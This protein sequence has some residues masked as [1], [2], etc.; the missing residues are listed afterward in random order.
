[1]LG[2]I[3]G[4]DRYFSHR[5][6][7]TSRWLQFLLGCLGCTALQKGPLWWASLHRQ[8]HRYSDK[9]EDVHSPVTGGLSWSPIGWVFARDWNDGK[10]KPVHDLSRFRELRWLDNFDWLPAL[11]LHRFFSSPSQHICPPVR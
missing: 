9:A 2:L 7:K 10:L 3:A 1:M 6:Y 4:F 8:H 11:H 5:S